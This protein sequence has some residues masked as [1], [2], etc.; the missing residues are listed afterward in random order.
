M[1][2]DPHQRFQNPRLA[3]TSIV[4]LAHFCFLLVPPARPFFLSPPASTRSITRRP[5]RRTTPTGSSCLVSV[6]MSGM[7]I[8]TNYTWQEEAYE[9]D[10]TVQVPASTRAKDIFF[11]ATPRSIDLRILNAP[12]ST[13]NVDNNNDSQQQQQPAEIV[14]LDKDRPLR[15]RVNLDGTYW[16]ISDTV[17]HNKERNATTMSATREVTVTIEKLIATPK[18]DFEVMDYDWKGLY[19]E[20]YEGEV[21]KRQYD[22]PEPLNVREYAAGLGV[23]IDNIDM[24]KVDKTMFGNNLNMTQKTLDSLSTAGLLS[25]DE[26]TMQADGSEYTTDDE[27]NPVKLKTPRQSRRPKQQQQPEPVPFLDTDSPWHRVNETVAQQTRNFTRAAFAEDSA[28]PVE[29]ATSSQPQ[30]NPF[31]PKR[32]KGRGKSDAASAE[33]SDPIDLL[34][35]EKL[36]EILKSQGLKVSGSK[37]ELQQRLRS[38]VNSLLQGKEGQ[39]MQ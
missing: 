31:Q 5:W 33:A 29:S 9:L 11:K 30:T 6:F 14:L 20:E 35:V 7:G 2:R 16:V 13:M 17:D 23:D 10:V 24:S 25:N 36:K 26:V 21:V 1:K 19:A 38:Q 3:T 37:K 4:V 27:G 39:G 32:Q 15:G 12:L 34:T 8:A 18:D 28:R 22:G